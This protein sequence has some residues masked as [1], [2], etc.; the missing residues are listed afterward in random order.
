MATI[1]F[2]GLGNGLD[3]G[4]VIDQLVKVARLPVDRLT[5]KKGTLNS[6]FTDY[7]T[8][9]TKLVMLQSAADKLRLATSYDRSSTSV[10]DETV[11]AAAGSST[12]TPG[13]YQ[14]QVTQLAQSHQIVSKNAKSVAATTTD[15]VAGSSATFT[16]RVGTGSDQTVTL[17]ATGT[18]ENLRDQINDLGA[19]V[20]ASIINTG[21]DTTPAYRLIL[22]STSTGSANGITVSADGTTLD[23]TNTSLTGGSDTLQAAQDATVVVGTTTT[24]TLTR[25]SNTVTDAISGVTLTLTDTGT[26]QVSVA[27]DVSAVQTNITALATAYNDV[28]KFI[29]ERNTYDITTKKGGV[30]FNEAAVRNVLSQVRTALSSTVSGASTVTSVGE[31][32]FKTERDGTI[33]LDE[34][35]LSSV[36]NSSYG[37]VKTL[38]INQTG[39]RGIAQLVTEAV[40]RL[41]DIESGPVT[42]RK[43]GL[44]KEINRLTDDIA[45][46]EDALVLYEERLKRQY[47]A[48]DGLLRQLNSQSNFLAARDAAARQ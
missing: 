26:A 20:A 23:F 25:S 45:R 5:D 35:K 22:T 11:L 21:S 43:N 31:I 4:Q 36:L 29:N 39:I 32:G 18:L 44:T 3:F 19:G 9:S 33:T 17:D 46:K 38:F 16:F 37:A 40:D 41:D 12:A 28:V 42:L 24:V 7:A 47:A 6:K 10:S 2:G 1:S 8:L 30:F 13:T 27:R 48:L 14:V 15:I 34:G